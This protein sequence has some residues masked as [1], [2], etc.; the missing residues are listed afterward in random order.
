MLDF[1]GFLRKKFSE[2]SSGSGQKGTIIDNLAIQPTGLVVADFYNVL[3]DFQKSNNILNW[4][5]MSDDQMDIFG[6][7]FF[8][9]RIDGDFSTGN[10]DI[11][12]EDRIDVN[13]TDELRFETS[14]GNRYI[15]IT[16]MYVSGDSLVKTGDRVS[17]Y[18]IRI[19]IKAEYK[20]GA[21]NVDPGD[22]SLIKNALFKYISISNEEAIID[23][24]KYETNIEYFDRLRYSINDRSLMNKR[25]IIAM[26]RNRFP[27]VNSTYISGAGDAYM[28][29]DLVA[30]RDISKTSMSLDYLGKTPDGGMIPHT[31][32]YSIY[33]PESGTRPALYNGPFSILS[34]YDKPVSIEPIDL[35]SKDPA[36]HGYPLDQEADADMYHG[37]YF[38]DYNKFM[39]VKTSVPFDILDENI[40]L[41]RA[42]LNPD[43]EWVIGVNNKTN[44]NYGNSEREKID[45]ISFSDNTIN[46]T[47]G[48]SEAEAITVSKN[49]KKRTGLKMT[50][51]FTMAEVEDD[52]S[53]ALSSNLQFMLGGVNSVDVDSFTG[54][55]FGVRLTGK[56]YDGDTTNAV[57]Y[58]AHSERYGAGQVFAST[59]DITSHISVAGIN[60]LA[61]QTVR[62]RSNTEY[63]FEFTIYDNLSLSLDIKKVEV[64]VDND[65]TFTPWVL[66][67][68]ILNAF[69]ANITNKNTTRYGETMK[70]TLD[71]RAVNSDHTWSVRNL[72]VSDLQPRRP[73]VLFMM[74]VDDIEEPASI[75]YRG[76]GH[77]S[78]DGIDT[79]GYMVSIWDKEKH[80]S[81]GGETA[82]T[83][84]GWF[85]V[86]QLSNPSGNKDVT[87][88]NLIYNIPGL[89]RYAI[90]SKYGKVVIFLATTIG[91]TDVKMTATG[92]RGV[93]VDAEI[94]VDYVK[95][96]SRD[97]NL[98]HANNKADIYVNTSKNVS[99]LEVVSTQITKAESQSFFRLNTDNGFK[100]PIES[101]LNISVYGSNNVLPPEDFS[102]IKG[103]R[104]TRNSS[105][106]EIVIALKN[107]AIDDI[108]VEYQIYNSI[109]KIQDFYD[110]SQSS[111]I[112][113]D[114]LIKHKYPVYLEIDVTYSGD[115][116]RE[117]FIDKIK[118]YLDDSKSSILSIRDM[119]RYMYDNKYANYILEPL[120]I[121]YSGGESQDSL[122]RSSNDIINIRE[123]D[124]F[125][126]K[127]ISA[128]RL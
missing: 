49:I 96:N 122:K 85:D 97:V 20:G 4:E 68:T 99:N 114:V 32:Y 55:G 70:V 39:K 41:G 43:N 115:L 15:A 102:I 103:D 54:I 33:P 62:I 24:S 56:Y 110:S 109:S 51:Y 23:G 21:Y 105:N 31:A 3:V 61:E 83:T 75:E 98:Y 82:F 29:R 73:N 60:A 8:M 91:T 90:N 116:I 38:D 101:I 84:G 16:P 9:P 88:D 125:T 1:I 76:S 126:I 79:N 127:T 106:D 124:Y 94:S 25:S 13:I 28:S 7:K 58:F 57:V 48:L 80:T 123:I 72:K 22:I 44:G 86:E 81:L 107:Q 128:S 87:T 40:P 47:A 5:E 34:N 17:K 108:S 78:I 6:G 111:K 50:G 52:E 63:K 64:E 95:I 89:S 65:N 37:L 53:S 46:F 45:I 14:N 67:S 69:E 18:K 42:I 2:Y 66:P 12:F 93:D 35:L 36:L 104:N 119:V 118:A 74:N 27:F 71:T 77:S 120:N 10:V 117:D 112:F 92:Q 113:G 59:D 30:A 121:F 11:Y 19:A 26:L 100:M